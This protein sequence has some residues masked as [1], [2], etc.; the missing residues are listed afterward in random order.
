[1]QFGAASHRQSRFLYPPISSI[2]K[3]LPQAPTACA[4][5]VVGTALLSIAGCLLA[6]TLRLRVTETSWAS[7][8]RI[9]YKFE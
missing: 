8:S 2:S 1:M 5:G 9:A 6:T 7:A 3:M 4:A